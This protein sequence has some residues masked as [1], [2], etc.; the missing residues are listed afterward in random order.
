MGS[1]TNEIVTSIRCGIRGAAAVACL[2]AVLTPVAEGRVA[3]QTQTSTTPTDK[4]ATDKAATGK[5]GTGKAAT[6]QAKKPPAKS[7]TTPPTKEPAQKPKPSGSSKTGSGTT[8]SSK[9]GSSKTGT[10]KAA[11]SKKSTTDTTAD[12]HKPT[13]QTIR[14][15]SAFKASEQL[16]PMAQQ[17]AV[18]RS[19]A[20]YAGV[21]SYARA[22]PGEGAAAAYLAIGHAYMLDHRYA[23][24]AET[25]R[26]A[27]A[28]GT[29]LD[30][31][32]DYLG[33]QASVQAGKGTDAYALLDHFAERHPESI[34]KA[35]APVLL[36]NAYLQQ[37]D[38]QG[39]L[40]VLL[41]LADSPQASHADFRY[42]L[43]R[44]Y[45]T[46]G[47]TTH[48]AATYRSLYVSLPLSM[49]ASQAR[50]Q[51]Q[52]MNMPLTAAERKVHADQLFNAK[53][54]AEAGESITRSNVTARG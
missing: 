8:G 46:S 21:E 36:A 11:K 30:D 28:S 29:A 41:P 39:A 33:A 42:A 49:E 40:R 5:T 10:S 35:N 27:N 4:I 48:A 9:A 19:A 44:A 34:F 12:S 7:K 45:Q 14:L 37:N 3:G 43:G 18:T 31:Y 15:T 24:A 16:R 23:D 51:M 53:R 13:P 17:L 26:R 25:F 54:Y 1:K 2:A 22:H 50:T 47:D 6:E 32:A 52:A 38:P 20:A